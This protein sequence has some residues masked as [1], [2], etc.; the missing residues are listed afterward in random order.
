MSQSESQYFNQSGITKNGYGKFPNPFFDIASEYIPTDIY[1]VFE[2]CEYLYLTMGT[3]RAASR[4]VVRYFLTDLSLEGQTDDERQEVN[5]FLNDDLHMKTEIAAIGDDYMTYGN[6]FVSL[7]FPFD[8]FI[9]CPKCHTEYKDDFIDYKLNIDSMQIEARCKKCSY[10]GEFEHQDRRSM[11]KSRVKVIRWNPK[12]IRFR[13]H[14]V[15]Q[16][17]TYYWMM[18]EDFVQKIKAGKHFFLRDTPWSMIECTKA[19]TDNNYLYQFKDDMIYHHKEGALAGVPVVG[20]GIPP[21]L[22]N[23]KLAY[24]IQILRRYDEAIALDYI[25]P[26]RVLYAETPPTSPNADAVV[27][28]NLGAVKAQLQ[29]MVKRRRED[30]TS[31]QIAPFQIGYQALGGEA[32]NLAPKESI[33]FAI[34]ELL[35][36]LGYPAE[37]YTGTLSI[38]AAPVALRLFENTWSSMVDGNN[39]IIS[40]VLSKLCRYFQWGEITGKF[41]SVTLA[42]DLERKSLAL[43]A[44]AGGDLSKGTA[45]QP[46]GIDYLAEQQR[47]ISEQKKVQELA[48]EAEDEAMSQQEIGETQGGGQAAA[49]SSP[50]DM[51]Q[52]AQQ[53]AQQMLTLP[54]GVRRSQLIDMKRSNP[55]LHALVTQNLTDMRQD[56]STQGQQM[57]MEQMRAE[58][59]QSGGPQAGP[60]PSGGM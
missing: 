4:R 2:W 36:A 50:S 11:D 30:P 16:K 5:D 28:A 38:Q 18:P 34:E 56:M 26:F 25:I 45:Y 37:L 42:D 24:Y 22:P 9:I 40:W 31:I 58:Q 46:F 57:M 54:D 27:S 44:S 35:N 13:Y 43:Q 59:Q 51:L 21:I 10:K 41:Q 60:P 53:M 33:K 48:Q 23:F 12:Q 52:Q 32:K 55:T 15:S 14:P 47:I 19:K 6:A 7:Y 8:R 39:D 3:Y 20:W 1:K 17:Y 49:A 29:H